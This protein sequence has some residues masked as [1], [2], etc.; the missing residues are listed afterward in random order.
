MAPIEA[1]RPTGSSRAMC[2]IAASFGAP[3]ASTRRGTSR[4]GARRCRRRAAGAPEVERG[5]GRPPL[6]APPGTC[7]PHRSGDAHAAEVVSLEVDDHHVL[8]P[9][10]ALAAMG[11]VESAGRVPLIGIVQTRSPRVR[12]KSSASPRR[13]TSRRRASRPR[14]RPR[15][16]PALARLPP[17]RPG[18]ARACAGRGSPGRRR[19]GRS[20]PAPRRSPPHAPAAT[21]PSHAPTVYAQQRG[22]HQCCALARDDR[23][24]RRERAGPAGRAR[25]AVAKVEVG[26][27]PA[28]GGQEVLDAVERVRGGRVEHE[29]AAVEAT[30]GEGGADALW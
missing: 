5:G 15:A 18:R 30:G 9:I 13:S 27:K 26:R 12:R 6:A 7:L 28:V 8:G 24:G 19:R 23:Q 11:S 22:R 1:P 20:Q 25:E 3:V 4:V 16:V 17:R 21:S 29:P 10:L 2:S 14:T